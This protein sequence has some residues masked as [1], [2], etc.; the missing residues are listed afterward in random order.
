MASQPKLKQSSLFTF[1][2][3][4]ENMRSHSGPKSPITPKSKRSVG[5]PRKDQNVS[6]VVDL[7]VVVEEMPPAEIAE[8]VFPTEISDEVFSSQIDEEGFPSEFAEDAE[9]AE[10]APVAEISAPPISDVS[11]PPPTKKHRRRY[12]RYLY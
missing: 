2:K 3:F 9:I 7:D 10:V 11:T 6:E 5:R 8:E 12:F 1:C 4:D